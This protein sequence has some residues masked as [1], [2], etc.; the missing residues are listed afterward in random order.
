MK[1]DLTGGRHKC[2]RNQKVA[3]GRSHDMVKP[4]RIDGV[5]MWPLAPRQGFVAGG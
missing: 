2:R 1:V 3:R 5:R 4:R